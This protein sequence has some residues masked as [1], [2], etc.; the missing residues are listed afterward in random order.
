MHYCLLTSIKISEQSVKS[1]NLSSSLSTILTSLVWFHNAPVMYGLQ[2]P[3]PRRHVDLPALNQSSGRPW[4]DV[5]E[6]DI[7]LLEHGPSGRRDNTWTVSSTLGP[8]PRSLPCNHG[9][10]QLVLVCGVIFV[11]SQVPVNGVA[12]LPR[13]GRKGCGCS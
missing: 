8:R 9:K 13:L 5:W 7:P 2:R 12:V 3:T 10:V 4:A 6:L 1:S 11:R